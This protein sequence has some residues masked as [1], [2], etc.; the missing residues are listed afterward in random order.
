MAETRVA[1]SYAQL[2]YE[3]LENQGLDAAQVLGASRPDTHQHFVPMSDWQTWLRRV[4]ALEKR[5]ALALRIAEGIGARHFG[6]LG[7]TALACGNLGEALQRLERYHASVYD[8][9]PAKVVATP[10]GIAIEWGVERGKPGSLV[11]ETAI[12]SLVQLA[13][14]MTGRY[15]PVRAVSFVNPAPLQTQPYEDFFGGQVSFGAP[16]TRL[17]FDQTYLA[18]PLRK[19]DPALLALMDQQAEQLLQQVAAVP[20]IVDAWRKT[21]VPLIREGQTSLAALA[22]AHHTSPRS[23]Q[24]RLA[25]QGT[26]F[27]QLLDNTRQHLAER[28][29]MD[30][31][32]DLAEI[33]LLLGYSEQSAFTRAFRA[34]TGLAPAQWRRQQLKAAA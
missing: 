12:A 6:V 21:L 9:N 16:L 22:A 32:L 13:R 18:L 1:A 15:W 23:L 28:H 19:S 20:A 30:A 24:R 26:S 11:D 5:P 14:D 8:A 3:Y 7:Y 17:E 33:A 10:D 25:E 31:K 2:L 27:Q 29:L 4:D 34:W